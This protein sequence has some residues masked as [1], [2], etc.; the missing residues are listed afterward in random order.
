MCIRDREEDRATL[1]R[2][3]EFRSG[4]EGI[5][6]KAAAV[7][8]AASDPCVC[9]AGAGRAPDLGQ[10]SLAGPGQVSVD[11]AQSPAG[12][13]QMGVGVNETGGDQQMRGVEALECRAGEGSCPAAYHSPVD[14]PQVREKRRADVD[15][16]SGSHRG[17]CHEKVE[18]TFHSRCGRIGMLH[19]TGL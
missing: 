14:N 13:A 4:G 9:R 8:P 18:G 10:E 15:H 12:P 6:G 2:C 19:T 1:G 5:V 11:I 16:R 3:V 7:P 17:V